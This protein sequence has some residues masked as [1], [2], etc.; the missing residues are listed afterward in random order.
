MWIGPFSLRFG[1]GAYSPKSVY[2]FSEML[3]TAFPL[4]PQQCNGRSPCHCFRHAPHN[5]NN[6]VTLSSFWGWF[7]ASHILTWSTAVCKS[8]DSAALHGLGESLCVHAV[9]TN[10]FPWLENYCKFFDSVQLIGL[11]LQMTYDGYQTMSTSTLYT[12]VKSYASVDG[13]KLVGFLFVSSLVTLI[14]SQWTT[15]LQLVVMNKHCCCFLASV[16]SI[17]SIFLRIC[18]ASVT[19]ISDLCLK[20]TFFAICK[21]VLL[22]GLSATFKTPIPIWFIR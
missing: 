11:L 14:V 5:C 1:F 13:Q 17:A 4:W 18:I 20:M 8:W 16:A 21:D 9:V 10:A 7:T 2:F 12:V 6:C 19:H 22:R 15:H 3:V